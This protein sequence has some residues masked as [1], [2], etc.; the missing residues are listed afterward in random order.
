M[1]APLIIYGFFRQCHEWHLCTFGQTE[2]WVA[3]C[4]KTSHCWSSIL[5]PCADTIASGRCLMDLTSH[6]QLEGKVWPSLCPPN[7]R[8]TL[9]NRPFD[10]GGREKTMLMNWLEANPPQFSIQNVFY[11]SA[12]QFV[13]DAVY[14]IFFWT[15]WELPESFLK[16]HAQ[17]LVKTSW[18]FLKW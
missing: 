10:W 1:R 2:L 18:L 13:F 3:C 14:K 6:H 15:C 11:T 16:S 12:N 9:C 4:C 5:V 8:I 7:N 17:V